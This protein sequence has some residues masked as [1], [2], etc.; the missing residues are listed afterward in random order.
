LHT[1]DAPLAMHTSPLA[2]LTQ[3]QTKQ[4]FQ[5]TKTLTFAK[6]TTRKQF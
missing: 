5:K 6:A 2:T 3:N 1:T 4:D